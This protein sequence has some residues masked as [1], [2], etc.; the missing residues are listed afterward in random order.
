MRVILFFL[1]S[2][3]GI[4]ATVGLLVVGAVL[5]LTFVWRDVE[6]WRAEETLPEQMVLSLDLAQG[7]VDGPPHPFQFPGFGQELRLREVLA[8]L[9]RAAEDPAV[10]GLVV[11]LGQGELSLAQAQELRQAFAEFAAAGKF[12]YGFAE[13]FGEAGNGTLHYYL[14]SPLQ[15]VWLQPSG[16]LDIVGFR[17][18]SPYLREVLDSWGI[19][20]RFGQRH[21]HKA[22]ADPLIRYAMP[23]PVRE[24]LQRLLDS[25]ME[26]FVAGIAEDRE[27]DPATVRKL[28][29]SAPHFAEDAL[30]AGLVDRL[31]YRDELH[32]ALT[33][34]T[35][36]SAEMVALP[37]Y[38]GARNANAP[39]EA[40][41]TIAVVYGLGPVV[42]D[43]SEGGLFDDE[44]MMA[45]QRVASAITSAA[46]DDDIKAIVFRVDSPGGSYVASDAIWR[47]VKRAT[48]DGTPVVVSM[49][50]VA[51]SGGYF[52]AAPA[53]RIV[54]QPGTITGSI[55]VLGGKLVAEQLFKDLGIRWDSVQAGENA[56]YL[57]ITDDFTPAQWDHLQTM[58]DRIYGDFTGKVAEGRNLSP[59]VVET[60]AGGRIWSGADARERGLVDALGGYDMAVVEAKMAAGLDADA[61][62]RLVDYPPARDP[63]SEFFKNAFGREM[64]SPEQARLLRRLALVVERLG[65]LIEQVERIQR[66]PRADAL[67]APLPA[68]PSR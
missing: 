16:D 19:E 12:T 64:R 10:A 31:A 49:G 68:Q 65:P 51:A 25:W 45:A 36:E 3:V 44:R 55:G 58:L 13:T 18:E 24:N 6:S 37:H 11:N 29:D 46:E 9:D 60:L 39:A 30:D 15:Q 32:K 52:V 59:E 7:L 5:A 42:L 57:T 67:R 4:L 34:R 62:V 26:Q 33:A 53:S 43:N 20:P 27:L 22:A 40:G 2:I 47:A 17:L 28:I 23:E 50:S 41:D 21:E 38:I 8:G 54:A 48:E 63:F 14:A 56:G 1:K 61:P 66:D 35:D